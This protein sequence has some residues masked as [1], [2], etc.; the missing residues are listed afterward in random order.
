MNCG[1][2]VKLKPKNISSAAKRAQAL[3]VQPPG[4]LGPPEVQPA[5]EGRHRAAHHDVMEVRD[6]EIG[7]VD[8]DV[9]GQRGEE[10]PGQA[11]QREQADEA[12]R[13]EHRRLEA[14]SCPR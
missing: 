8:V 5:E 2:K 4:D 13:V 7:V 1:K 12:Q 14:R 11:A 6:D 9:D 10:Q 3:R